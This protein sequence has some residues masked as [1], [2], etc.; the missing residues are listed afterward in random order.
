MAK[1]KGGVLAAKGAHQRLYGGVR[2]SKVGRDLEQRRSR[3]T[4]LA[5]GRGGAV[6]G[7]RCEPSDGLGADGAGSVEVRHDVDLREWEGWATATLHCW[8]LSVKARWLVMASNASS[9]SC[10]WMM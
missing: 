9:P 8:K 4:S 2:V 6:L 10:G 1:E 7:G 5:W 3:A